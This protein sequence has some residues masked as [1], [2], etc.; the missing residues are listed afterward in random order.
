[1]SE[2]PSFAPDLYRGT[3]AHYDR[4]RLGYPT[5]LI[6]GL[7]RRAAPSGRGRLLDLAC[8]TGQLAFA[9]CDRFA[10]V[11]AVDQEPD[12][13]EV[14]R[15]KAAAAGTGTGAGHIRPVVSAAEDLRAEPG[16]FELAVIGNAFHRLRRGIVA[17]LV[18]GW[19]RPGGWVALCW[20]SGTQ[21]GSQEWQLAFA[22]LLA[23]WQSALGAAGR[24]PAN[25]EAPQRE[26]PDAEVLRAAGFSAGERFELGV[27]HAWTVPELAGYVRSLSVLPPS[28]LGDR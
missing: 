10:E 19:L 15:A 21:A 9:L 22:D 24:V 13:V 2:E 20:S 8:G 11:W 12:M 23:R 17:R 18:F 14:V 26:Q 1:M 16:S 6:A 3:A 7:V 25:W 4:F 28:V 27:P 5:E